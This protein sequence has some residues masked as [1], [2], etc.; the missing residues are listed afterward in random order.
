MKD[1]E[2][3]D[4]ALQADRCVARSEEA[5]GTCYGDQSFTDGKRVA[6]QSNPSAALCG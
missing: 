3:L 6:N 5:H 1:K 2:A 4:G